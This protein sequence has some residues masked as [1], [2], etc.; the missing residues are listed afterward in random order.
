VSKKYLIDLFIYF[1]L[2]TNQVSRT[3]LNG[4]MNEYAALI[5]ASNI[6]AMPTS[7]TLF[8]VSSQI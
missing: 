1:L 8:I 3:V 7:N 2:C 4:V 6:A 5:S